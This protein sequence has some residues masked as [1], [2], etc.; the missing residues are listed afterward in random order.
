MFAVEVGR[1]D[2]IAAL[3]RRG[4]NVDKELE[5]G[6]TPLIHAGTKSELEA[7]SALVQVTPLAHNR[8]GGTPPLSVVG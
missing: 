5:S 8:A 6:V 2:S 3:V 1:V 4:A 7:M